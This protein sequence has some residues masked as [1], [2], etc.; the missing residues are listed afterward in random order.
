MVSDREQVSGKVGHQLFFCFQ[1]I[2]GAVGESDSCRHAVHMGVDR[3]GLTVEGH[4]GDYVGG[5]A[6]DAGNGHELID[7]IRN[8][9]VV[10]FED[11]PGRS[12]KVTAFVVGV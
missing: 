8:L 5:F 6:A 9:P 7:L 4:G 12:R 3:E 11:M 10:M 2:A 1:G